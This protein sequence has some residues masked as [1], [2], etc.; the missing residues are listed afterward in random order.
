MFN[1]F[2]Y[3]KFTLLNPKHIFIIFSSLTVIYINEIIYDLKNYYI[4]LYIY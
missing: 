4:C 2:V 1:F 3:W